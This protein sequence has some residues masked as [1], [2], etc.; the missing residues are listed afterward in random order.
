M[1]SYTGIARYSY[2]D[3]TSFLFN[4]Y[5][6]VVLFR[7]KRG[8]TKCFGSRWRGAIAEEVGMGV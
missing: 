5:T 3:M 6:W 7:G 2:M 8:C 1:Y 4:L